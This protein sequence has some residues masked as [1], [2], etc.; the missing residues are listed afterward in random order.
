MSTEVPG[1]RSFWRS[2]GLTPGGRGSL[3]W[4]DWGVVAGVVCSGGEDK[5]EGDVCPGLLSGD[6]EGSVEVF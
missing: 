4:S 2:K 5:D 1:G 3:V 6:V